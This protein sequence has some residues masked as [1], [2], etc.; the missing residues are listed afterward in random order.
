MMTLPFPMVAYS[1]I[2]RI[3]NRLKARRSRMYTEEQT[4]IKNRG[5]TYMDKING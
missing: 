1:K 5:L 2:Q 4:K 3:A